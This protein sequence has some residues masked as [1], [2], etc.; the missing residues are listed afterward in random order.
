VADRLADLRTR[1]GLNS[2][3]GPGG[4]GGGFGG[5]QQNVRGRIGQLKGQVMNSTSV[6]ALDDTL[7]ATGIKPAAL[8]ALAV[9]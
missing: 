6:P 3:G 2:Q 5:Q 7:G 8:K 4:G 9:R 1:L